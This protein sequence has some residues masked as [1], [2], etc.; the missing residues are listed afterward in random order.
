[1]ALGRGSA[2]RR[3]QLLPRPRG[4]RSPAPRSLPGL[5]KD[6]GAGG[7]GAH[8]ARRLLDRRG[9][10]LHGHH[11]PGIPAPSTTL[12]PPVK[13]FA[14]DIDETAIAQARAAIYPAEIAADLTPE[15]LREFFVRVGR[16]YQVVKSL[17]EMIVFA[18]HS[19]LKDPPFSRLDL[20]VCRNFLIYLKPDMQGQIFALF[21]LALKPGGVLFLGRLGNGP[22]LRRRCSTWSTSAGKST[23]GWRAT[24]APGHAFP[25]HLLLRRIR[26]GPPLPRSRRRGTARRRNGG[27]TAGRP[28]RPARV[29]VN[30]KYEVVHF[31]TGRT[32]R[33]LEAP[34]GE[35]TRD[36]LKMA[37]PELRSI[38]RTA[39]HKA[40][41]E[42]KKVV[43]RG[44]KIA[45][46]PAGAVDRPGRAAPG[47]GA[48]C[49]SFSS[50]RPRSSRRP[51]RPSP[52]DEDFRPANRPRTLMIRQLEEQLQV[53]QEQLQATIE[54]LETSNEGLMSTNEELLSINEEFQSTNE[55]L[56]STNEELE[57]SR[58]ELQ[59]LN[60]ELVTVNAELQQKVEELNQANS[61][62]DNLLTSSEIATIFL[63]RESADQAFHPG[64]GR[65]LPTRSRPIATGRFIIFREKST[66]PN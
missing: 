6:R 53:T 12:P 22:S 66:G 24:G 59:A 57:T 37:R 27:K 54:Q 39:I 20:L 47:A 14:T 25:F 41:T 38:L 31:P 61:D 50:S 35:P 10:L 8:L 2:D 65:A 13:I 58:E 34:M 23:S 5:F 15:R 36:I 43:F 48:W 60:E 28:L 9:S 18:P 4:L 49:W 1:M 62:M 3:D 21:H 30:E 63:D 44:V 51:R 16:G 56:H 17:R 42:Q 7:S 52:P 26:R 29:V 55:E 46:E 64:H 19:L 33:F 11:G 45:G 32:S 40:F